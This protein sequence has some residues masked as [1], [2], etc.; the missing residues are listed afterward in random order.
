MTVSCSTCPR[1]WPQLQQPILGRPRYG[2]AFSSFED[3]GRTANRRSADA[4]AELERVCLAG[5]SHGRHGIH[6]YDPRDLVGHPP[7]SRLWHGRSSRL[8]YAGNLEDVLAI[9][10]MVQC[11]VKALSDDI[12]EGAYQHDCHPMMVRQNKWRACRYGNQA[13]LVNSYTHEV[14]SIAQIVANL[15]ER[16]TP[17]AEELGCV[18]YLRDCNRIASGTAWSQRQRQILKETGDAK[19]VVRQLTAASRISSPVV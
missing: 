14:Q 11:L 7:A 1:C 19:E 12:D 8:R 15:V 5:E 17:T 3:H 2:P 10:A 4:D 9:A 6:Q 18:N 13:Q 16:L